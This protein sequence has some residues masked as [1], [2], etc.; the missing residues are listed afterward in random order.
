[1]VNTSAPPPEDPASRAVNPSPHIPLEIIALVIEHTQPDRRVLASCS[2]VCTA[3]FPF[4]RQHLFSNIALHAEN[5]SSFINLVSSSPS[6]LPPFI[7]CIDVRDNRENARW[8]ANTQLI[9]GLT[10]LADHV[11]SLSITSDFDPPLSYSTLAAFRSFER[12]VE[13]KLSGCVFG[14]FSDAQ[15]F[16]CSFPVLQTLL[17]EAEWPE[18]YPHHP[19]LS[20]ASIAPCWCPAPTLRELDLKCEIGH[21]LDWLVMLSPAPNISILALDGVDVSELSSINRYLQSLGSSL[22]H[23]EITPFSFVNGGFNTLPLHC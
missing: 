20:S 8:L 10:C 14:R 15:E 6:A 4:A 2:L 12:L 17:L 19:S 21:V 22:T 9:S 1:M 5:I 3:W 11:T 7:N 23:L 13:L 16:I 18:P